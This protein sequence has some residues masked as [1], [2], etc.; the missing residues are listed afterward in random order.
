MLCCACDVYPF[1]LPRTWAA[2]LWHGVTGRLGFGGHR[3]GIAES[4]KQLGWLFIDFVV[5][6]FYFIGFGNHDL[7]C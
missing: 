7:D 6:S 2:R 3:H 5:Y 4:T 1:L